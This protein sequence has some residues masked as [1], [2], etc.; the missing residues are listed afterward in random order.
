MNSM[1]LIRHDAMTCMAL[2]PTV[3][4]WLIWPRGSAAWPSPQQSVGLTN[5]AKRRAG[6][7][8]RAVTMPRLIAVEQLPCVR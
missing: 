2:Q 4:V 7:T 5:H 1:G 3:A 8:P 6:H